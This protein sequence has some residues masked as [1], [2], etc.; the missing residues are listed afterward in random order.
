MQEDNTLAQRCRKKVRKR[1]KKMPKGINKV[2]VKKQRSKE[3]Q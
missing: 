1:S 3:E 2:V